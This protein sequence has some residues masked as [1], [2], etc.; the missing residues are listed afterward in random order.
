MKLLILA[1]GKG[2]RLFPMSTEDEP[3]Q[4]LRIS[5]SESLLQKTIKRCLSLIEDTSDM[6]IVTNERY[7]QRVI[8]HILEISE[9]METDVNIVCEP[10]GRNTLPA[11]ALGIKYL[12]E[13]KGVTKDEVIGVFPSDHLLSP[14]REFIRMVRGSLKAAKSG[15]IVTFGIRPTS[16]QTAFGYIDAGDPVN[17]GDYFIV[18]KFHEKPD[19]VKASKYIIQGNFYWNSGMYVFTIGTFLSEL[20][21][22][23]KKIANLL[24]EKNFNEF[25]EEFKKLPDISIDYGIMENTDRAVVKPANIMWSDIGSWESIYEILPKDNNG[26]VKIGNVIDIDTKNSMIFQTKGGK[27]VITVGINDIVVVESDDSIL[28]L[29]KGKG[30][31]MQEAYR[32]ACKNSLKVKK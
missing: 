13:K 3:K 17:T 22:Y 32:K 26:N 7:K 15:Y 16:P 31:I 25:L 14:E 24:K 21:R 2:T 18:R 20:E 4:F 27:K 6:V 9:S 29:K 12:I 28:I 30:H 1:G 10:Y 23:Q 19:P 11:V 8:D 5:D